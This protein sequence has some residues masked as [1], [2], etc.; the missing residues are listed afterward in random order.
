MTQ[1]Q[2]YIDMQKHINNDNNNNDNYGAYL[3]NS[4]LQLYLF[5]LP[6]N[7]ILLYKITFQACAVQRAPTW[8]D[9][10]WSSGPLHTCGSLYGGC[11][12]M[13]GTGQRVHNHHNDTLFL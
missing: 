3:N 7:V 13:W 4:L 10:I 1:N 6:W 11:K 9:I 12:K 2:K 5:F 8:H